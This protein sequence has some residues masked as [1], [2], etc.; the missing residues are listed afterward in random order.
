MIRHTSKSRAKQLREYRKLKAAFLSEHSTC[1]GCGKWI[2]LD[3]R[4]LHHRFGRVGR[5]LCWV[6]GFTCACHACHWNIKNAPHLM[7]PIARAGLECPKGCWNDF[8]RA[9]IYG[10]DNYE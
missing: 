5:L 1:F 10:S 9:K 8:E 2:A 7:T 4:E 6:P 3:L